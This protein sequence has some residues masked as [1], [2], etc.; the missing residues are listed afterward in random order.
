MENKRKRKTVGCRDTSTYLRKSPKKRIPEITKPKQEGGPLW[1]QSLLQQWHLWFLSFP[2]QNSGSWAFPCRSLAPEPSPVVTS[3]AVF[4]QSLGEWA[5][6]SFTFALYRP[7]GQPLCGQWHRNLVFPPFVYLS[8]AP[9]EGRMT[10]PN[11]NSM[12]EMDGNLHKDTGER[13]NW[14]AV[15]DCMS[16]PPDIEYSSALHE[17]HQSTL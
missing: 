6:W 13:K 4:V 9:H 7:P 17:E 1:L 15:H 11:R 3:V 10:F 8:L 14:V 12:E 2:L 16:M 5:C